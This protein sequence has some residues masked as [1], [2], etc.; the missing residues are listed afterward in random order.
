VLDIF[1]ELLAVVVGTVASLIE[2]EYLL[3]HGPAGVPVQGGLEVLEHVVALL[4]LHHAEHRV[5]LVHLGL[6]GPAPL[7]HAAL[8][9]EAAGQH[10]VDL[11]QVHLD[12]GLDDLARELV[13]RQL[14]Q[15]LRNL[16]GDDLEVLHVDALDDGLDDL[17]PEFVR[18]ELLEV[19]QDRSQQS[20]D[21]GQL[22][23]LQR[24][25]D[26]LGAGEG[27]RDREDL[28]GELQHQGGLADVL[29]GTVLV[30]L[31]ELVAVE[32]VLH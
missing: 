20:V 12:D 19:R 31:A 26:H 30:E 1:D 16:V 10:A 23:L 27:V 15:V 7:E 14:H 2:V 5:L 11:D 13:G 21:L 24:L 4:V 6:L 8:A 22:D 18:G 32:H 25:R 17:V 3:V 29:V 28:A 9:Q